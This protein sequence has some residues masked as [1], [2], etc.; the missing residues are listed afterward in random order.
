MKILSIIIGLI[1]LFTFEIFAQSKHRKVSKVYKTNY[2]YGGKV[3]SVTMAS[4]THSK[5]YK[6]VKYKSVSTY[7]RSK[8]TVVKTRSV[9]T[10][11]TLPYGYVGFRFGGLNYYHHAGFCYTYVNNIYRIRPFPIG[12]RIKVLPVG[13]RTIFY[14]GVPY[15][16][17][18]GTYYVSTKDQSYITKAPISGMIVPDLPEDDVEEVK[19]G[20]QTYYEYDDVLYKSIPDSTGVKYQVVAKLED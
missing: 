9:R 1:S 8:I 3:K 17:Y 6:Y 13:Y 20:D 16:Y 12:Y 2:K 4:N 18:G 19:I 7:S 14:Q 15:Y 10:F 11:R 5:R